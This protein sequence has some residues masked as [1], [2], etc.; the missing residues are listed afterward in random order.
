VRP[1]GDATEAAQAENVAPFTW[2]WALALTHN[3]TAKEP[4]APWTTAFCAAACTWKDQRSRREGR[5]EVGWAERSWRHFP[6]Q[7]W[8]SGPHLLVV[9]HILEDVAGNSVARVFDRDRSH[10][11]EARRTETPFVRAFSPE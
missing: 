1:P 9:E 7:P 10:P 2:A 5:S 3:E 11:A 4:T 8:V 6:L